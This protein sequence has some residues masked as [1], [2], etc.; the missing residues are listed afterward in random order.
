[1]LVHNILTYNVSLPFSGQTLSAFRLL[2]FFHFSIVSCTVCISGCFFEY[3]ESDVNVRMLSF[4]PYW[5]KGLNT[6][7]FY[8]FI[9]FFVNWKN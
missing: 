5:Q 2:V 4:N 3:I 7:P 9:L 8:F 6:L 1:M